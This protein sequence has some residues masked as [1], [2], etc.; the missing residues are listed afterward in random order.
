MQ[1]SFLQLVAAAANVLI[2]TIWIQVF[3]KYRAYQIVNHKAIRRAE[4]SISGLIESPLMSH[5]DCKQLDSD[6]Y[7]LVKL[8]CN[9]RGSVVWMNYMLA[10]LAA[11][12]AVFVW[13]CY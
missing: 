11:D 3:A 8:A 2:F 13:L 6:T 10:L 4:A 1:S 12:I 5:V 7:W 9:V